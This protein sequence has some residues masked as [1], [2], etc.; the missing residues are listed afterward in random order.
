MQPLRPLHTLLPFRLTAPT[1]DPISCYY[2]S[3]NRWECDEND[4][5]NV[6]FYAEK[7]NQAI[8]VFLRAAGLEGC[9]VVTQHIR[10]VQEARIA[11]P[12]RIDCA[13]VSVGDDRFELLSVMCQ[14]LTD[15]PIAA[16]LSAV[17]WE[18]EAPTRW[19]PLAEVPEWATPRGVDPENLYTV[20]D[21]LVRAEQLGFRTMGRGII[22][23]VECDARGELLLH[24][25]VGRISDGMPNLWGF[26]TADAAERRDAE[27][28]LG[29]A[30]VEYGLTYR[31][32][33]R[34]GDVFH[35]LSGIRSLGDKT[36]HMVH[37]VFNETTE[38]LSLSA[39]AIGVAMNL[40][41]RRAVSISSGR[42]AQ[43]AELMLRRS[44]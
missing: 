8:A 33:L 35:Q 27:G 40:D 39:E 37:L 31:T 16:F 12:L 42:R 6:R 14:N 25:Y 29:G 13:P 2:G 44:G 28:E 23:A 26:E 18:D 43:M 15:D 5:L 10:F 22:G 20:P 3:V 38:A 1:L 4:H 32:P 21:D 30:V 34:A 9:R 7:M 41:T 24:H 11:T 36:Q 17:E 19:Q